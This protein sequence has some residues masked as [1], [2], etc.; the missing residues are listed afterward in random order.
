MSIMSYVDYASAVRA[1]YLRGFV[2]KY[3]ELSLNKEEESF[4]MICK[5]DKVF[6][7]DDGMMRQLKFI[8]LSDYNC[9]FDIPSTKFMSLS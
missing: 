8:S 2:K 6:K 9:G 7:L 1:K 4:N 5:E 3:N